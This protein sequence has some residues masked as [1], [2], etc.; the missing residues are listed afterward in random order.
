MNLGHWPEVPWGQL[1]AMTGEPVAL[2]SADRS[3]QELK[4]AICLVGGR[5]RCEFR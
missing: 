3:G 4:G 2:R 5:Q 1:G